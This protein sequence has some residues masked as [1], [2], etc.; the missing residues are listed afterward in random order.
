M[1]DLAVPKRQVNVLV[2]LAG[3]LRRE[4]VLF[5]AEAAPG[6]AGGERLSDLLNGGADFIPALDPETRAMSFLNC[7]AVMLAEAHAEVEHAGGDELTIPTEHEVEVSL[8]DGRVLRGFISYLLPPDHGRL[9][10]FLNQ[11]RPFL[12]LHAD[13][14]VQLVHKQHITRIVIVDR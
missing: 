2:T 9:T 10:D 1:K 11:P 4:V 8:N 13:D 6:H 7:S 12:P 14:G 5:L 3:G